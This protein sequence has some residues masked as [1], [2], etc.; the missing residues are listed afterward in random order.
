MAERVVLDVLDAERAVV[1][2]RERGGA[3]L[4]EE[5]DGDEPELVLELG[6]LQGVLGEDE[7]A[8]EVGAVVCA[9]RRVTAG[10]EE[11]ERGGE[12]RTREVER[13]DER[14]RGEERKVVCGLQLGRREVL[15][16]VRAASPS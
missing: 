15:S 6:V 7:G 3:E 5:V 9:G 10:T 11:R 8:L 2:E 13:A 4:P 1:R 16:C 14:L 12:G